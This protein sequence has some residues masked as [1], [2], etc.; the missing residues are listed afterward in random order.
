MA[1]D[2]SSGVLLRDDN[3]KGTATSGGGVLTLELNVLNNDSPSGNLRL[4]RVE[5]VQRNEVT[6]AVKGNLLRYT[7]NTEHMGEGYN[8]T[9]RFR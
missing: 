7:F 3:F 8:F 1:K 6:M 2:T 4:L 5:N 9:D